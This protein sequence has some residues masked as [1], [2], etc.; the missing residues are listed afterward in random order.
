MSFLTNPYRFGAGAVP[1]PDLPTSG[2]VLDLSPENL[3]LSNGAEVTS[4]PDA[5]GEGNNGSAGAG[6]GGVFVTGENLPYGHPGIRFDDV[7]H[8]IAVAGDSSLD[9]TACTIISVVQMEDVEADLFYLFDKSNGGRN[10]TIS[11]AYNNFVARLRHRVEPGSGTLTTVNGFGSMDNT[12]LVHIVRI[13]GTALKYQVAYNGDV[14]TVLDETLSANIDT[15]TMDALYIQ[16]GYGAA[17]MGS[18]ARIQYEFLQYNRN[19]SDSEIDDVAGY[20]SDR[21]PAIWVHR[22]QIGTNL[23]NPWTHFKDGST[24]Y[25]S[26]ENASGDFV[27]RTMA[28]SD[29]FPDDVSGETV[30]MSA[31]TA[32]RTVQL[33]KYGGTWYLYYEDR[34]NGTLRYAKGAT[35][36]TMVDQGVFLSGT[37]TG[38]E[39]YVR[40]PFVQP[41]GA[42][43]DPTNWH[44]TYDG[45]QGSSTSGTGGLFHATSTDGESWT[46]DAA[47]NP[48]LSAAGGQ[49]FDAN[50]CGSPSLW[51]GGVEYEFYWSGY[52]T[53]GGSRQPHWIGK[54]T[55]SD[56]TSV[57]RDSN[58]S[59]GNIR[60][61]ENVSGNNASVAPR[62]FV[63]GGREIILVGA[64]RWNTIGQ[65]VLDA[66]YLEKV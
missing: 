60:Q 62:K 8:R 64:S 31:P 35:L 25:F 16:K 52:Y 3:A 14:T 2:L 15:G 44:M 32:S 45:R 5:S 47:N 51:W 28:D 22:G 63:H 18:G 4:F 12:A 59:I 61:A 23:D 48:I 30:I 7:A 39:Q 20:F 65:Q 34:A 6:Q 9:T 13:D 55:S 42:G 11:L 56:L 29:T 54:G 40:H 58:L 10:D 26:Y 50:D 19:L 57:T 38:L 41:P 17:N 37:G 49:A 33:I 43:H 53:I 46:R 1:V 24:H 66:G 27:Y 36:A 21:Y